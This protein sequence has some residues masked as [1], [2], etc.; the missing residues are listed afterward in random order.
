MELNCAQFVAE[1]EKVF[2]GTSDLIKLSYSIANKNAVVFFLDGMIDKVLFDDH[3]ARPL[4][5][6]D[7][8]SPPYL[9][10]ISASTIV[11][12][13]VKLLDELPLAIEQIACGNIILAIDNA[14]GYFVFSERSYKTRAVAEPPVSNVLKGPREGFVEDFKTNM[15]LLRR[16]LATPCARFQMLKVG[17]YTATNVCVAYVDGIADQAVVDEIVTKI[18]KIDMDGVIESSYIA[19]FLEDKP[20]SLFSQ[21]GSSEKPDIVTAKLLEGR[22]AVIVDGSPM[23]LTAPFILYEHFQASEDYYIKSYRATLV[24]FVRAL[25]MFLAVLLPALYVAMQEF[26]AHMFPLKL[27]LTVTNSVAGAPL[28][29]T[30]E[31]VCV[32][33]IFEILAEAS[34]RMPRYIGMA[35]S[36]VGAIVLG[37]TAVNAGLLSTPSILVI[38]ISTIGLYC[39]PD[40]AN[41]GSVLR[42][43]FVAIGGT[44]G[45]LGIVLGAVA[46]TCYLVSIKSFG[47]DYIAPFAPSIIHDWQDG[48]LKN[49]L[50][51]ITERPYSIPTKN[52]TRQRDKSSQENANLQQ[53]FG[54]NQDENSQ[55]NDISQSKRPS[56]EEK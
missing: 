40:E 11:T 20:N 23:V 48:L 24:R 3:I 14:E 4:K 15:T 1:I 55:E 51:N 30:M 10:I 46:L 6:L 2:G 26:Q 18:E 47:A 28:T 53:D 32:I 29:P 12:T 56:G 17:R 44:I 42:L 33:I 25:A 13:A 54:N 19:R 27:L 7:E 38:S 36:V 8:L 35:L 52:R 43:V 50:P 39:V 31:M 9:P 22:V 16:R 37:E 45:L 49:M 5:Q 34:V 21:V 41:T